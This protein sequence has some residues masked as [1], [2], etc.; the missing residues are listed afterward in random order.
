MTSVLKFSSKPVSS[1]STLKYVSIWA[2]WIGIRREA[3]LALKGNRSFGHLDTERVL[4]NRFQETWPEHSVDLDRAADD[5]FRQLV[6][7]SVQ[8]SNLRALRA[9]VVR[10]Q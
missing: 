8:H 5:R 3:F 6:V 1:F 4:V 10:D 2:R 9:S 7:L